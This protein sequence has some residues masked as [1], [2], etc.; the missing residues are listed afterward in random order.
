MGAASP[1]MKVS[2]AEVGPAYFHVEYRPVRQGEYTYVD[3][4]V[5]SPLTPAPRCPELVENGATCTV[6]EHGEMRTV[7]DHVVTLTRRHR[8]AEAELMR[9]KKIDHRL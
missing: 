6:D 4:T 3:L 2:R 1:G 5:R 9:E 8:A 7:R